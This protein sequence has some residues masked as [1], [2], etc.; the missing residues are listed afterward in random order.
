VPHVSCP[1]PFRVEQPPQQKRV[2]EILRDTLGEA[3]LPQADVERY[4]HAPLSSLRE[5]IIIKGKNQA[6]LTDLPAAAA[7]GP[8]DAH[9][10]HETMTTLDD[11]SVVH[12]RTP[13]GLPSAV[14]S[15]VSFARGVGDSEESADVTMVEEARAGSI[16][17][18]V[19][20]L[21]ERDAAE[22]QI[23][24][25]EARRSSMRKSGATPR[26]SLQQQSRIFVLGASFGGPSPFGGAADFAAGASASGGGATPVER[27][28]RTPLIA[29]TL[30]IKL[31]PQRAPSRMSAGSS[32]EEG[33]PFAVRKGSSSL[34]RASLN[35]HS[36]VRRESD[37]L[38]PRLSDAA[39]IVPLTTMGGGGGKW[40]GKAKEKKAKHQKHHKK[41]TKKRA[42]LDWTRLGRI[43]LDSTTL[44]ALASPR[45]DSTRLHLTRLDST[46]LDL[47]RLDST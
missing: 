10:A 1:F 43:A 29:A 16:A 41:K 46:R 9:E 34:N 39:D 24:V 37:A 7:H 44:I 45:L 32:V 23:I 35:R 4:G 47:T 20:D 12:V 18:M 31:K 38:S 21:E 25:A 15:S 19:E 42:L 26:L 28:L 5:R 11:G 8:D 22:A 14:S 6:A 2:A 13:A 40:G 3:I 27:A 33:N 36:D 30:S 17:V